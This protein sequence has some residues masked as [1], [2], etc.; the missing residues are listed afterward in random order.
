M[1]NHPLTQEQSQVVEGIL[2]F[3][4]EQLRKQGLEHFYFVAGRDLEDSYHMCSRLI[5]DQTVQFPVHVVTCML[6][7]M[8]SVHAAIVVDKFI[9]VL[10]SKVKMILAMKHLSKEQKSDETTENDSSVLPN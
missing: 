2:E 5:T 8:T 3:A 1:T 6:K 9:N 7:H 10:P 4:A